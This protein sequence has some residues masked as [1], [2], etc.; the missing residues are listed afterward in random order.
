MK[1]KKKKSTVLTFN[2]FWGVQET[3]RAILKLIVLVQL[4]KIQKLLQVLLVL[5]SVKE[6]NLV[7]LTLIMDLN[8]LQNHTN[9]SIYIHYLNFTS[10]MIKKFHQNVCPIWW[11]YL[12]WFKITYTIW[13]IW[14]VFGT[15]SCKILL[16][17]ISS[18]PLC[19]SCIMDIK[20]NPNIRIRYR[21]LTALEQTARIWKQYI[22]A[23]AKT[24]ITIFSNT[25]S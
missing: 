2:R 19:K 10:Y 1:D 17:L 8:F 22:C 18:K 9:R 21:I 5:L 11:S 7:Y 13:I 24:L 12:L 6:H 4:Y 23:W 3:H 14:G 16:R 25:L 15:I 20:N